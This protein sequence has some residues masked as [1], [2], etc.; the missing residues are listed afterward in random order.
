MK[1]RIDFVTNSSSSSFIC[2]ICGEVQSGWDMT[3]E[4]AGM[5]GCCNGHTI[6]EEH[7]L[8]PTKAE[9]IDI[10]IK[11]KYINYETDEIY[12]AEQLEQMNED[13]LID[14]F[15]DYDRGELPE[16]FCPICQFEEY[17]DEDM[18]K[19]LERK[20][21][22]SRDEVFAEV[23]KLN[24]RRRKLYDSEYIAYVTYKFDLNL[25][26]IQ[27]GWKKEFG[28]YKNFKKYLSR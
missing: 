22:V 19:Y 16:I 5:I 24:R 8:S 6:C 23:K 9:M 10:I 2:D 18:A 4:E 1:I 12:T 7:M 14:I 15:M 21:K 26:E 20:Y 25:G 27:S 28:T 17:C 13:E 11:D 3:Y